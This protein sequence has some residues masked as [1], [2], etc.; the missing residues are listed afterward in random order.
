MLTENNDEDLESKFGKL[1]AA[2]PVLD[3]VSS[4]VIKTAVAKSKDEENSPDSYH[5]LSN[6][7]GS[8][9]HPVFK[10]DPIIK[11]NTAKGIPS[12]NCGQVCS[13]FK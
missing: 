7:N 11:K 12:N 10:V 9:S 2:P 8:E 1:S 6:S 4:G 5:P 13:G 3:L